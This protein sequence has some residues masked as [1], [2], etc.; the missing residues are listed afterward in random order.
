MIDRATAKEKLVV[1]V[2]EINVTFSVFM[3]TG[4]LTIQVNR[5][6]KRTKQ[7]ADQTKTLPFRIKGKPTA[8]YE[9]PVQ[10]SLLMDE[11]LHSTARPWLFGTHS[12]AN[13]YIHKTM[14]KNMPIT[15]S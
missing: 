2:P 13:I 1:H 4:T 12:E 15:H 8:A 14:N 5:K 7:N 6:C 3:E 11:G 9:V 10:T